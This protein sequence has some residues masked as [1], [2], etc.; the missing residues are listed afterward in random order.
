M[1]ANDSRQRRDDERLGHLRLN[2]LAASGADRAP[3]G[4]IALPSL[5]A[6]HEQV[7]DVGARDQQ[8]DSDGAEQDPERTGDRAEHLL[9]ERPHDGAVLLD[10]LRV[11]RRCRRIAPAGASRAP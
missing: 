10:E 9:L 6:N 7:R 8:H 5:G 1:S 11:V 4:E 2:Q 3:N